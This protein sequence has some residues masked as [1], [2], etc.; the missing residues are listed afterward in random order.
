MKNSLEQNNQS[1]E[2]FDET[3]IFKTQLTTNVFSDYI[4]G[5]KKPNEEKKFPEIAILEESK[6]AMDLGES[7]QTTIYDNQNHTGNT[8]SQSYTFS[9]EGDE[10][11]QPRMPI[12]L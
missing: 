5:S 1:F 8:D 7:H 11:E 10:A 4:E 9:G 6:E 2:K 3:P 12:T